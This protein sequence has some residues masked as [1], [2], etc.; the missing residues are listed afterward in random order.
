M[1]IMQDEIWLEMCTIILNM[2]KN[3]NVTL[4]STHLRQNINSS[5]LAI[6]ND[7]ICASAHS[8][9]IDI[10]LGRKT[11]V[12]KKDMFSGIDIFFDSVEMSDDLKVQLA[13]QFAKNYIK[14]Y[15]GVNKTFHEIDNF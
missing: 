8:S 2:Q 7:K 4:Y 14:K 10:L 1:I 11:P 9:I 15:L 6:C 5:S 12:I 13:K 3:D